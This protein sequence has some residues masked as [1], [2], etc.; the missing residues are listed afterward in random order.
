MGKPASLCIICLF[1]LD[2]FLLV[3]PVPV[4]SAHAQ[5]IYRD[6]GDLRGIVSV[7][8]IDLWPGG[9]PVHVIYEHHFDH[10]VKKW[11]TVS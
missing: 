5:C 11:L 1:S 9:I 4:R 2:Q 7:C 10:A 3:P 6:S 8:V